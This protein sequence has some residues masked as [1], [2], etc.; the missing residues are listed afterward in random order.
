MRFVWY[1]PVL[2]DLSELEREFWYW[3]FVERHSLRIVLGTLVK[4]MRKLCISTKFQQLEIRWNNDIF[5]S[6]T[7]QKHQLLHTLDLVSMETKSE[8][9]SETEWGSGFHLLES[10]G[11]RNS[12]PA[13]RFSWLNSHFAVIMIP[14]YVRKFLVS[15]AINEIA[16]FL[17]P[18][19]FRMCSLDV[20]LKMSMETFFVW[21]KQKRPLSHWSFEPLTPTTAIMYF[22]EKLVSGV[23]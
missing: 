8:L 19:I 4:T 22:K 16:N 18:P 23:R 5:C 6:V 13:I 9:T 1:E 3:D 14:F 21:W 15:L 20:Y 12:Q 17:A 7:A 10:K 2:A 11:F